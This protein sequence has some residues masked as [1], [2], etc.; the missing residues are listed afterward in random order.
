M[1]HPS[2]PD[3]TLPIGARVRSTDGAY[4]GTIAREYI[5]PPEANNRPDGFY[6]RPGRRVYIV[7]LSDSPPSCCGGL[8]I[9]FEASDL[10][11][12]HNPRIKLCH[13]CGRKGPLSE[14]DS[15]KTEAT[16]WACSE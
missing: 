8:S 9:G 13:F 6:S 7:L 5:K 2:N 15:S 14:F 4:A 11:I 16:C 12:T 1:G 3:I 10:E